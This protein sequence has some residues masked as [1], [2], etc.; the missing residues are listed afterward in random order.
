MSLTV[1]SNVIA[2]QMHAYKVLI[3]EHCKCSINAHE[4]GDFY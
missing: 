2:K 4:S 1:N 3:A